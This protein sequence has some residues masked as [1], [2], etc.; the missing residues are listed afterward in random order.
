[1]LLCVTGRSYLEQLEIW[2]EGER[3]VLVPPGELT[4]GRQADLI[5]DPANRHLHRVLARLVWSETWWLQ[6]VGRSIA[7]VLTDLDGSSYAR[8]APSEAMPIPFANTAL[9]FSAGPANYRLT[10]VTGGPARLE[11]DWGIQDTS[12]EATDSPDALQFNEEQLQLLAVLGSARLG[13]PISTADLPSSRQMARELGWSLSKFNRKLD[14]LCQKLGR[15]GV[16]GLTGSTEVS[17]SERRLRLSI[18][19]VESGLV[20]RFDPANQALDTANQALDTA[21]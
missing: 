13:G 5:V 1:M 21:D 9:S 15:A 4:I 10:I 6:N 2:F 12:E 3:R 20:D 14:H 11:G 17:A 8:V 16:A 18:F 7:I 19:A